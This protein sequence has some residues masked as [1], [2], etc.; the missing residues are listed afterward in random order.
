MGGMRASNLM[1]L[2]S[3]DY[4]Q[5]AG[6]VERHQLLAKCARFMKRLVD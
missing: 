4:Y 6:Q 3:N 5:S 1:T 2:S